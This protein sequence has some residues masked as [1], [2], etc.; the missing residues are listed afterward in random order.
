MEW[1]ADESVV[2]PVYE[3]VRP[4]LPQALEGCAVAGVN[5]RWRLF[6]Y[7]QD[8]VYRPHIDGSWAGSGLRREP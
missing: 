5:A 4:H 6:R 7:A 2:G 8:C 3:R 1:L